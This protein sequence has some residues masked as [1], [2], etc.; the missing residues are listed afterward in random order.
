MVLAGGASRRLGR[1]KATTHVGG[2]R[3]V[4]RLLAGIGESVPVILVGPRPPDLPANVRVT[5]EDPPGTGPLAG[6]GAGAAQVL[7]PVVAVCAADMPFALPVLEQ[8][9][10]RVVAACDPHHDADDAPSS[11][12]GAYPEVVAPRDGRGTPQ[13]LC[14]VYRTDALRR[15]LADLGP[16][17][18][19]PVHAL[20]GHLRVMEWPVPAAALADVDTVEELRRARVRAG[21]EGIAMQQWVDAVRGALDLDVAVDLDVI[22]DVARDAAHGVERPAAPVTTYLLGAAVAAG[23][24]PAEAAAT[25]SEL[26][27]QWPPA[28]R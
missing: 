10:A 27:A 16:L 25:V 22:L 19:R 2:A 7:T 17:A 13:L 3:L 24:D 6:L 4:D 18:D 14:A 26:A 23:A 20:L 5:R 12:A 11:T 21:E 1:D 9:A 15:A 28:H 8:M